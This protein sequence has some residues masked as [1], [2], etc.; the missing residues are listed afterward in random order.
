MAFFALTSHKS[1]HLYRQIK[2]SIIMT[3][4]TSSS[5][6]SVAVK[7]VNDV[8]EQLRKAMINADG[9]VLDQLA[10]D[11]LSYGHSNGHIQSKQEFISSFTSGESVFLNIELSGQTVRVIND[12]AIVR[13]L[14]SAATNDR[15][16]GPASV[17]ISI[18]LV[19]I[20]N[21]EKGWQLVA[22]QAVKV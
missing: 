8:V 13:H 10:S 5:T 4:P 9:A 21:G 2:S 3:T 22:R 15:G 14:L 11:E 17:K 7:E 20:K 1:W 16:K 19:W 18:V 12:T 6:N